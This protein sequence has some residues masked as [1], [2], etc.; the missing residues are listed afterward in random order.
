MKVSSFA[1]FALVLALLMVV[2]MT[3]ALKLNIQK[4]SSPMAGRSN[5]VIKKLNIQP[6]SLSVS[7]ISSGGFM[8]VQFQMAYSAAIVGAGVFAGKFVISND[9]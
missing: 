3:S 5:V 8:A 4:T 1:V 6:H 2:S 7:G 9:D